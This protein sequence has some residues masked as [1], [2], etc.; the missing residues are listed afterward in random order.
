ME[1]EAPTTTKQAATLMAKA[2]GKAFLIAGGT[3]VM[4]RLRAGMIDPALV[5]D[6]KHIPATQSITKSASGVKIGAAVS[7][8]EIGENAALKKAWPGVVEATLSLIHI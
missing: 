6:I 3:D 1:Y 2:K 4:V 8:A 7:G 5:V